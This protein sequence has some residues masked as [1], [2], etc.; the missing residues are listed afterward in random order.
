MTAKEHEELRILK[1]Y[2]DCLNEKGLKRLVYLWN[3]ED[4]EREAAKKNGM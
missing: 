1:E 2:N 4:K 3:K